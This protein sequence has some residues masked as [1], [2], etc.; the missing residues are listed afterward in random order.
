MTIARLTLG[1][2]CIHS[3][4]TGMRMACPL[5]VLGQG[6]GTAVAGSVVALFALVQIFLLLPVGRYAD[7]HGLK[8]PMRWCIAATF[9]GVGLAAL[10]PTL[11]LVCIAAVFC[12]AGAGAAN[13]VLQRHVGRASSSPEELRRAFSWLSIAPAT[14]NFIGP[15]VTG[16]LIDHAGYPSAFLTLAL[17]P[18]AGWL[19]LRRV[20]ETEKEPEVAAGQQSSA[21]ELLRDPTIRRLLLMNWFMTVS[22]DLHGLM[23]PVL[24][25]E[26]GISA[27]V[28]GSIVGAFAIGTTTVRLVMPLLASRVRE[29]MLISGANAMA[30]LLLMLYPF[31]TSVTTMALCSAA[32]GGAMGSMQ[33]MINSLLHQV[34]PRQQHG[35][36]IALRLIM[37]NVSMF[38]MPLV[39]GFTGGVVGVSVVFWSL[40]LAVGGSSVLGVRLRDAEHHQDH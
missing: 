8:R 19:V 29:W 15:L 7:R 32:L 31:T 27:S 6:Y 34:T 2:V 5:W 9:C 25:H 13:L 24:A 11:P 22:W 30:G 39:L 3:S 12:G 40:G 28:T 26:R 21:L 1:Q 35:Q 10:W 36:A 14:A 38:A 23:V 17:V 20:S 37:L 33:P 4:L 18:L 16:L